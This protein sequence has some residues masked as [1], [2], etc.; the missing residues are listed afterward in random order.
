MST[1]RAIKM[2]K[3]SLSRLEVERKE[4]SEHA[5]LRKVQLEETEVLIESIIATLAELEEG[6]NPILDKEDAEEFEAF[7]KA[8]K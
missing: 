2:L 3:E 4:I 8:K 7:I 1:A 6:G 5:N